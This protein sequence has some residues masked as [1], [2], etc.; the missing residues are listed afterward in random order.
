[1]QGTLATTPASVAGQQTRPSK[2]DEQPDVY[3]LL[4]YVTYLLYRLSLSIFDHC[5]RKDKTKIWTTN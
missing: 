2:N 4:Y 3:L 5:A 1:M